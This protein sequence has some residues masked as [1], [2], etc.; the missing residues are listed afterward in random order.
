MK[1]ILLKELGIDLT[2]KNIKKGMK[3]YKNKQIIQLGI[4]VMLINK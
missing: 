1:E 4:K 2:L 3:N